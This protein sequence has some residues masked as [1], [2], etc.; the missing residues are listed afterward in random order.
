MREDDRREKEAAKKGKGN[1]EK[2][3]H[4]SQKQNNSINEEPANIATTTQQK[5]LY[6]IINKLMFV[7]PFSLSSLLCEEK[8]N[9]GIN[10]QR[11]YLL[12]QDSPVHWV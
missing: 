5:R 7:G 3:H 1:E 10:D 12:H 9:I 11:A 8:I 6:Q 2:T 4:P